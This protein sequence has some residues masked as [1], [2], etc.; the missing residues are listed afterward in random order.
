MKTASVTTGSCV[1]GVIVCTP[2]PV[3][4]KSIVSRPGLALASR[5][6]WRSEPAPESFVF[7]TVNVAAAR[8]IAAVPKRRPPPC[9]RGD[10][11]P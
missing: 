3:M 11:L 7:V 4:V 8:G 2:D 1:A 9:R 10:P 6:A 5:I